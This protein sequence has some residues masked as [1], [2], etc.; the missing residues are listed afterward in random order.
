MLLMRLSR[1]WQSVA[2]ASVQQRWKSVILKKGDF[3]EAEDNR[4]LALHSEGKPVHL[5][6]ADLLRS[7]QSVDY[8]LHNVLLKD[9]SQFRTS[10]SGLYS[11]D[12]DNRILEMRRDGSRLGAVALELGRTEASIR[13]RMQVIPAPNQPR[14]VTR[15]PYSQAEK[16]R[17]AEMRLEKR[18]LK[19]IAV[20]LGRTFKSISGHLYGVHGA[21]TAKKAYTK[22]E[23]DYIIQEHRLGKSVA[24]VAKGLKRGYKSVHTRLHRTLLSG[25][26]RPILRRRTHDKNRRLFSN[27]EFQQIAALKSAGHTS[28][29]SCLSTA[30][31]VHLRGGHYA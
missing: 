26:P 6:S 10:K 29:I 27:P 21:S 11:Q 16:D 3:S 1:T 14:H 30:L 17:I 22:E 12:E 25:G 28:G 4:I 5:V 18:P 20:D 19:E 9:A 2:H 15:S 23:D 31:P 13:S 24:T 8:R 7:R